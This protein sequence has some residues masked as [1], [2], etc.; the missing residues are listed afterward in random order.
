[1]LNNL[2]LVYPYYKLIDNLHKGLYLPHF[3]LRG[4]YQYDPYI[5]HVH[6]VDIIRWYFAEFVCKLVQMGRRVGVSIGTTRV[7]LKQIL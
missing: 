1:M 7:S 2:S 6:L 4:G 3:L 5:P